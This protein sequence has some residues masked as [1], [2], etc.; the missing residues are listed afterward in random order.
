MTVKA[1]FYG[2]AFT[3]T[4]LIS[5]CDNATYSSGFSKEKFATVNVGDSID[6]VKAKVGQPIRSVM[7]AKEGFQGKVFGDKLYSIIPFD[8]VKKESADNR[9]FVEL[10]YSLQSNSWRPYRFWRIT[11]ADG[12]VI[13]RTNEIVGD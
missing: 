11:I 10:E 1:I 3:V 13:Q 6:D 8:E 12:R 5:G 7:Y 9:I 2:L 4:A